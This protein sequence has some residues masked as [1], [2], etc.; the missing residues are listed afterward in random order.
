M[1]DRARDRNFDRPP[2]YRNS[3]RPNDRADSSHHSYGPSSPSAPFPA[4]SGVPKGPRAG[5][6]DYHDRISDGGRFHHKSWVAPEYGK[7]NESGASVMNG[8]RLE[9]EGA[10]QEDQRSP[11]Q[12][13]F[14]SAGSNFNPTMPRKDNYSSAIDNDNDVDMT[15]LPP[16]SARSQRAKSFSAAMG[17]QCL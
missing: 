14:A 10:G 3:Y 5:G 6:G 7:H 11:R 15:G 9:R 2:P 1:G 17:K 4:R 13:D 16:R 12:E 8:N